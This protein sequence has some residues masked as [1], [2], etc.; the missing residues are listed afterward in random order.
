MQEHPLEAE[1]AHFFVELG[2]AILG[3]AG[4]RMPGIGRMRPKACTGRK[5]LI[6]LLPE[7]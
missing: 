1:L 2:I 5:S 7:A 4:N 3:I 6:A